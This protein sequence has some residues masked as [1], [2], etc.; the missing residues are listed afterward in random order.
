M[1]ELVRDYLEKR[2]CRRTFV[3][4]LAALGLTG[5]GVEAVCSAA[6]AA[7]RG[8][9]AGA[10]ERRAARITGTGGELLVAQMKAAGVRYL[11]TNPGSYEVGLFDAFAKQQDMDL[12]L[13]LHDGLVIATADG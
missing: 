6:D 7:E 10:P 9:A 13:G 8:A 3:Q 11:F 5:A 2:V 1:N 12:I 4:A